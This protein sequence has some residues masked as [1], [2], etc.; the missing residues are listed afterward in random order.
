MPPI[1]PMK[2]MTKAI[3]ELLVVHKRRSD[4]VGGGGGEGGAGGRGNGCFGFGRL[5]FFAPCRLLFLVIS[6]SLYAL[7]CHAP[8]DHPV[9]LVVSVGRFRK[10]KVF[11]RAIWSRSLLDWHKRFPN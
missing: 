9:V 4:R 3:A 1:K 6:G 10:R 5:P 11:P 8:K 2:L 7:A